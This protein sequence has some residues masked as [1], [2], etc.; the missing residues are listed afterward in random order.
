MNEGNTVDRLLTWRKKNVSDRVFILFLSVIVG[1]L[2]GFAAVIIKNLVRLIQ[3]LLKTGFNLEQYNIFYL[4]LPIIGIVAT[5]VFTRYLL[6]QEVGHGIPSVLYA[7]SKTNG[8]IKQ[9]NIFS[10]IVASALTV[11]FGGS[12]GLEGPAVVTGAAVGSNL[13]KT[14][15]LSYK[16]ILTLLGCA[17]AGAM[18]AIFKAPIAAIVFALEV[19]MLNLTMSSLIPLLISS[20][21]AALTSYIFLG[22]NVLYPFTLKESFIIGDVPYFIL[23]GLFTGIISVYFTRMYIYIAD[24]F[25]KITKW[26]VKLLTG[27]T[28]LGL[29]IFVLPALFGEGYDGINSALS[30][31][32]DYL[33]DGSLYFGFRESTLAVILVLLF[34]ILFKVVATSVTFGSGGVGGIFAPTLFVGANAGLLFALIL[35]Q[36]GVGIEASNFVLVAMAGMIAGVIHA[37]LTAIFLIAEITGGYGLFMPLMITA[38][39][40]YAFTRIFVRNSVYTYQLAHRGELITHD[41]DKAALTLMSVSNLIEQ[42]FST[43]GPDDTLGDLVEVISTSSRNVFPVVDKINNF[44]GVVWVNDIRHIVFKPGLYATTYVRDLMFMPSPTVSPDESMEDVARKFQVSS[45]YNLAVLD[46]GK[47]VGFVS[48]ANVFSKYRSMIKNFMEE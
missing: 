8:M 13:G 11:G 12:V 21:T 28:I 40:S 4:V 42:N 33:F 43:V 17:A 18:A 9:H 3:N 32:Y 47:Y 36:F 19:I 27:G 48:R 6:R 2:S 44:L 39:I 45:H 29:I 10:S 34:L 30:A 24:R 26:G 1:I 22:Q 35:N 5:I 16:Q 20:V 37:P 46:N 15:R 41:K 14:L 7:I 31:S 23:L 38:T 25:G